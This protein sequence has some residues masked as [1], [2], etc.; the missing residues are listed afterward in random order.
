[1]IL[2]APVYDNY[3][4]MLLDSH[5]RL[6]ESI[7]ELLKRNGVAEIFLDDWRMADVV[8]EPLISPEL[9]GK[10][11]KT[12]YM[13]MTTNQGKESIAT[14]NIDLVVRAVNAI[15][16]EM[17]LETLVSRRCG[18]LVQA[19]YLYG[20]RLKQRSLYGVGRAWLQLGGN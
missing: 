10:A 9:E 6:D 4:N 2:G 12:L 20:S 3:G 18:I 15:A 1:M 11:A 19:D 7:L 5:I 13:L 17:A 8:V 14:Q 16:N